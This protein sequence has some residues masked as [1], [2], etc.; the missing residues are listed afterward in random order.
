MLVE[1]ALACTVPPP[2]AAME[3]VGVNRDEFV[4]SKI[5]SHFIER[6][7]SLTPMETVM[8]IP[9]ELEHIES[10]VKVARRKKDVEAVNNQI[11]M[12]SAAPTL[13]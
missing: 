13:K 2:E 10:L 7:I 5:L 3:G 8:M 9:G 12:V 11:S 4:K 6:K 1:V